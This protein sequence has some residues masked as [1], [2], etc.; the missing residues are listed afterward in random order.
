VF[1]RSLIL[2]ALAALLAAPAAFPAALPHIRVEGRDHT[3]FGP[4]DPRVAATTALDA[5]KHASEAGEFFLH[6]SDTAY[7]PYVDQIGLYAAFGSTGWAYKVNGVS[8]PVGA[9]QYVLKPGDHVLW[10]WALFGL[11]G[12]PKTLELKRSGN[13]Y[14]VFEQDDQGKETP[15]EGAVVRAD[16]HAFKARAGRVCIGPH[17]GL[18]KASLRG[19][20]R[21]NALP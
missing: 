12:G 13:C 8:P 19:D 5:L 10:Y 11:N 6:L 20:V 9:D 18:V 16:G 4:T 1:R 17:H 2:A 7:G 14:R 21:S 15:A 3:I